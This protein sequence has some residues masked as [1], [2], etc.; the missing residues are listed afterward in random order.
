MRRAA[1]VSSV[2]L[3]AAAAASARQQQQ[4]PPPLASLAGLARAPDAETRDVPAVTNFWGS[5]GSSPEDVVGLSQVMLPPYLDVGVP[6]AELSLRPRPACA[7][8]AAGAWTIAGTAQ[9]FALASANAT[10]RVYNLSCTTACS[11]SWHTA[12]AVMPAP[13]SRLHIVF[14]MQPGFKPFQDDGAFDAS[15]GVITWS[16]GSTWC[17][18]A[19]NAACVPVS[20]SVP[21]EGWQWTPTGVARWG[22]PAFSET[23]MLFE[24][25]GVL[26]RVRLAGG[27]DGV[28]GASL[29]LTGAVQR[30]VGMSWIT[31]PLGSTA[32]YN[33][34]LT[35]VGAARA[36]ALLTCRTQT[37]TDCAAWLI[38]SANGAAVTPTLA[39]DGTTAAVLAIAPIAPGAELELSIALVMAETPAATLALAAD[40]ADGGG[41]ADAWDGFESGWAQRWE[42]AFTPKPAGGGGGG[43]GDGGGGGHFSGSLPVL[44][45]D[46]SPEG[47]AIERLYYMGVLAILQAE[48]TNLPLVA[49][50]VYVTGTGNELC[51]IAVGGS[52]QWAW[53][54]VR[55]SATRRMR[56]VLAHLSLSLPTPFNVPA[57]YPDFLRPAAG[58]AGPRGDARGPADV[59][60]AAHR[61]AHGYNARQPLYPG[62]VVRIQCGFALPRL[63][64]LR[65]HNGRHVPPRRDGQRRRQQQRDG[66]PDARRAR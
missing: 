64:D 47:T 33:A 53:D 44:A 66:R 16:G 22:G 2:L 11:T 45:L 41:F 15:C 12:T 26:Q 56:R 30:V 40:L 31:Q 28:E 63:L 43:G 18:P 6:T 14:N 32:G 25:S 59:G 20:T 51:G 55:K 3:A 37:Q 65:A 54:Q 13:F 10:A 24:G 9:Y 42:D 61:R 7:P 1:A 5:V 48:R 36:S 46:E 39:G 38:A 34:S 57:P 8:E 17:A 58:P 21:L 35:L 4:Q 50:R 27:A 49:P 29:R 52:E 23:R 62:R 60:G 19:L